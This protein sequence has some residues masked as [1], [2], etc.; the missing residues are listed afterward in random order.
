MSLAVLISSNSETCCFIGIDVSQS[1]MKSFTG[2]NHL[3]FS[4]LKADA[5]FSN[6]DLGA[7]DTLSSCESREI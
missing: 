3:L 7:T 1:E 5:F 2:T 6:M 4:V